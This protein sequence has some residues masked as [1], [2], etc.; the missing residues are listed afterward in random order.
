MTLKNRT[1]FLRRIIDRIRPSKN[2]DFNLVI[3]GIAFLALIVSALSY[4][5][6][7]RSLDLAEKQFQYAIADRIFVDG[8]WEDASLMLDDF[9]NTPGYR[10]LDDSALF[11][12]LSAFV[13]FKLANAS[14]HPITI[15][16]VNAHYIT[17]SGSLSIPAGDIIFRRDTLLP[18]NLPIT[19]QPSEQITATK[20]VPVPLSKQVCAALSDLPKHSMPAMDT[21]INALLSYNRKHA[22]I[23][24]N[25]CG[26]TSWLP[27][28]ILARVTKPSHLPELLLTIS[29]GPWLVRRGDR[30]LEINVRLSSG[31]IIFDTLDYIDLN[32]MAIE[33]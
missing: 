3:T 12:G 8:E 1:G 13:R 33:N 6:T 2:Y 7:H 14:Q 23:F 29:K 31:K 19:L 15:D 30:S 17:G 32:R 16:F 11:G 9:E 28:W 10:N 25:M 5:V 4:W 20:L 27:Q 21:V 18:M 22:D 26:D 24:G